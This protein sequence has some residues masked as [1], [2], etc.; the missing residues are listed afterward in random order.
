MNA[1]N[2]RRLIERLAR[3]RS[4]LKTSEKVFS[5]IYK[6]GSMESRSISLDRI[7][8]AII[9]ETQRRFDFAR[10]AIILLDESRKK[11]ECRYWVGFTPEQE[12]RARSRP[13]DLDVDKCRE[14]LVAKTGKTVIITDE[15]DE[16][17]TEFDLRMN[18]LYNRVSTITAPLR[19]RKEIIGVM[20]SDRSDR[21]LELTRN[22]IKLYTTFA[23]QVSVFIENARL[24]EQNKRKIAQLLTIQ[25]L[26]KQSAEALNRKRLAGLVVRSALKIT[27]GD[28]CALL[29]RRGEGRYMTIASHRG[30]GAVKKKGFRLEMGTGV[31][32]YVAEMGMPLLIN[33]IRDDARETGFLE[34]LRSELAVP[35]ITKN[36]TMGVLL[37]GSYQAQAFHRED[38]EI[39]MILADRTATLIENAR[40]YEEIVTGRQFAENILESSPSGI[41]TV[42][43]NGRIR[44]INREAE[45]IFGLSRPSVLGREATSVLSA[46]MNGIVQWGL[47]RR[48]VV[49]DR[50]IEVAGG[51]GHPQVLAVTSSLLKGQRG[52]V[53]DL[54]LIVR[55]L[56]EQKKTEEMIRRMDLLSSLGQLS[57]GLA[58]EIR[59]PLASINFNVQ[60]LFKKLGGD[61]STK[62][63]FEDT[64]TGIT[65]INRLVKGIHDFARPGTPSF[66]RCRLDEIVRESVCLLSAQMKKKHIS[67]ILDMD[68]PMPAVFLDPMKIQQVFVNLLINAMDAMPSGGRVIIQ[69]REERNRRAGA[70]CVTIH[71]ADTGLGI[72]PRNLSKIFDPFFTTKAEGTGLGLSIVHKILELHHATIETESTEGEGTTFTIRFPVEEVDRAG[73]AEIQDTDRR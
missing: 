38:M 12:R 35:L 22:E 31:A 42:H 29:L 8:N 24:L 27:Q 61:E 36:R 25:Q 4:D 14:T 45:R 69:C 63:V 37:V 44:S 68:G 16:R 72:P 59:N 19:I 55:D 57:A 13:L 28:V 70:D 1:A 23:N 17:N 32:G 73:H 52:N 47:L 26:S 33:E 6:I 2:Y 15:W 56:T 39:L 5:S 62:N 21:T 43:S 49:D 53:T 60:M 9:Q 48:E 58:H 3:C 67:V 54:I 65:R 46:E 66:K 18:K 64:L 40:L 30:C 71:V 7:I 11:M 10:V 34:G 50:E 41:I 51:N 20:A